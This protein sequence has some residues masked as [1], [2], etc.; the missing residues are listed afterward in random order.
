MAVYAFAIIWFFIPDYFRE[1]TSEIIE[2]RQISKLSNKYIH[3]LDSDGE[4][5][6]VTLLNNQ[7]SNSPALTYYK[8]DK[9][10]DQWNLSGQWLFKP[11]VYFGDFNH[12]GFSEVICFTI[13]GDSIFLNAKELLL[14][15]GFEVKNRFVTKSKSNNANPSDVF[16]V[17]AKFMDVNDDLTDEFVFSLYSGFSIYP[18]HTFLYNFKDG[19]FHSSPSAGSGFNELIDFHD[20]NGDGIPEITGVIYAPNNIHYEIP[21][22]DSCAWLMVLNPKDS[23]RFLFKPIKYEGLFGSLQPAFY[24]LEDEKYIVSIYYCKS[25]ENESNGFFLR[26][27]DNKGNLLK[28]K[29]IPYMNN[30]EL[31]V[32]KQPEEDGRSIYLIDDEGNIFITDTSLN[33][34]LFRDFNLKGIKLDRRK[35]YSVDADADGENEFLYIGVGSSNNKLIV[36]RSNF[37]E[38]TVVDLPATQTS[39]NWHVTISNNLNDGSIINLQTE[40][41]LYKIKYEKSDI[42]FLKYPIFILVYLLLYLLFLIMQNVQYRIAQQKFENEKLLIKQKMALSKKQLEPHFMLNTLNNIGNMFAKEEK[43]DAQYYFGKFASLLHRGLMYAEKTETSL[44]EELGF[45]RDYLVLQQ[46]RYDDFSFKIEASENIDLE[47]VL[48]P[49][50]LVYT[51]VENALKHGLR[52]KVGEK[53]LDLTIEKNHEKVEILIRDNGVGRKGSKKFKT[54]GTGKGL[55]IIEN[56]VNAYNKL[57]KTNISFEINDLEVGVEVVIRVV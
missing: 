53:K 21:Y 3:D 25:S 28:E 5:E 48:V 42:Y 11:S 15:D 46:R 20:I 47:S 33:V 31:F 54:S 43:E 9:I 6:S 56:I 35:T 16:S 4:Y 44:F 14:E 50:S 55:E 8:N 13:I 29:L 23:L 17:D 37:K 18:R 38:V 2:N 10:I 32:L 1:Y 27:Y 41:V 22:T 40:N 45:V 51:F 34:K 57:N 49:H 36:Y 7:G 24:S 26:L 30:H 12:N 52:D 39:L 19:T